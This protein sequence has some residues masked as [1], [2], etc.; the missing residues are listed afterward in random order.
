MRSRSPIALVATFAVLT[1]ASAALAQVNV[2]FFS[3]T[4]SGD[5]FPGPLVTNTGNMN[6]L[7]G[8]GGGSTGGGIGDAVATAGIMTMNTTKIVKLTGTAN[9]GDAFNGYTSAFA[10]SELLFDL[11]Q[12][13]LFTITNASTIGAQ[14]VSP[15]ALR[16]IT[17]NINTVTSTLAPGRYGILFAVAAGNTSAMPGTYPGISSVP[18]GYYSSAALNWSLTLNPVPT[19][20][21]LPL[22]MI[23]TVAFASRRRPA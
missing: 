10:Q 6:A 7:S 19:P 18:G 12:S 3:G 21:M 15:V 1:A 16:S 23:A 4:I 20:A 22:A 14:S 9:H 2:S 11:D 13:A 17:G 5:G 8:T